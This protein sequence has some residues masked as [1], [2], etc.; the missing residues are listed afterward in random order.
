MNVHLKGQAFFALIIFGIFISFIAPIKAVHFSKGKTIDIEKE[1]G[2]Y[3]EVSLMGDPKSIYVLSAYDD[4]SRKKRIQ[5]SQSNNVGELLLY[6]SCDQFGETIYLEIECSDNENCSGDYDVDFVD[7]IELVDGMP[8]NYYINKNSE[9]LKFTITFQLDIANVW[10]RGQKEIVTEA[11]GYSKKSK[12]GNSGEIYIFKKKGEKVTFYVTGKKGDYINVGFAEYNKKQKFMSGLQ[13]DGPILTGYL[14]KHTLEEICY[15]IENSE[16]NYHIKGTGIIFTKFAKSYINVNDEIQIPN[17]ISSGYF[18]TSATTT[19]ILKDSEI[20]IKF[21]D[22]SNPEYNEIDEI[23]YT[24]Q[25]EKIEKKNYITQEPQLN[26]ILYSR[27]LIQGSTVAYISHKDADFE[28]MT[29]SLNSLEGFPK[30][31]VV[32]CENYPLCSEEIDKR[33]TKDAIRPRNIN[34]FSSYNV[35][36]K[37][38]GDYDESPI[39]KKQTLF[40]VECK[41]AINEYDEQYEY[42]D[43]ICQYNSLIYKDNSVVEL[44]ERK[45]YNQYALQGEEH[46]FKILLNKQLYIQ[47]VFIDVMTYVGEVEINTDKIEELEIKADHYEAIHKKYISVKVNGEHID[48]L[49]FKVKALNNTYYTILVDYALI[50][51]D[52]E[53]LITNKLESGMSYLVTVDNSVTSST[54]KIIQFVNERAFDE[55][56][57]MVNFYSLNCEISINAVNKDKTEEPIEQF[58]NFFNEIIDKSDKKYSKNYTY[59]IMVKT[60]DPSLFSPNLCKIYTSAIE[61]SNGHD[62][63]TRDILIPDNTPQQIRF[64]EKAK[65]FSIGY[66]HVNFKNNLMIKFNLKQTARYKVQLFYENKIRKQEELTIVAN[67]LI[68]LDSTE[69]WRKEACFDESRVCYIQIDIV[70]EETKKYSNP[71][72]ELSVKSMDSHFVDYIPKNQLKIDYVQNNIPQYYYTELGKNENGFIICN[73]LRGS[74]KVYAKLVPKNLIEPETGANW[75]GKYRLPEDEKEISMIPFT[76]KSIFQ[77]DDECENGCY[78]IMTVVSDVIADKVSIERNYPYSIIIRSYPNNLNYDNI[79]KVRIPLDQYI[80]GSV[81]ASPET[82]NIIELYTVWLDSDADYVIIDFQ[83]DAGDMFINVGDKNP[84]VDNANFQYFSIGKDTIHKIS[85]SDILGDSGKISLRDTVLTIGIWA[86]VTDSIFTTTFSFAIRLEK[87]EDREI[88]RVSSDQKVL[89]T[90]SAI[91]D[92]FEKYRCVYIMDYDFIMDFKGLYVY[93]NVQDKSASCVIYYDYINSTEYEMD[94]I[95]NIEKYIPSSKR[96]SKSSLDNQNTGFLYIEEGTNNKESYVIVSV[97]VDTLTVIELMTTINLFQEEMTVNPTSPQ[98]FSLQKKSKITLK[99][100]DSYM[101]MI[102]IECV[103]GSGTIYWDYEKERKYYLKGRDDRL[104]ITSKK[105]TENKEHKL[106]IENIDSNLLYNIGIIFVVDYNIRGDNSNFDY[107]NLDKSVN[108]IY[109][110]SDFPIILY[111]P[112]GNFD[113]KGQDY[114]DIMFNFYDLESED[115]K[116]LTFYDKSPFTIRGYIVKESMIYNSKLNPDF[117]PLANEETIEGNYDAAIRSG[118]IRINNTNIEKSKIPSYERPYLYLKLDKT[119]EFRTI[120]KYKTVSF[121]TGV[122]HKSSNV[123]ISENSNHFG[124][125][126]KDQNEILYML[127]NDENKL[128]LHLEFSCEEDNLKVSIEG[129]D[130]DLQTETENLYGKKYYYLEKNSENKDLL[131]LKIQRKDN[132]I[133]D[134][135]YF[136]FKY[137]YSTSK[138]IKKYKLSDTKL[139]V[140]QHYDNENK[141]STYIIQMTPLDDYEKYNLTYIVKL[142]QLKKN[143]KVPSKSSIIISQIPGEQNIKE[144]YNPI[145]VNKNLT[146]GI[147]D[148]LYKASYIQVTVQIKNEEKIE[149]ISYDL[150]N[151]FEEINAPKDDDDDDDD[152]NDGP[153]IAAII[154]GSILLVI[155]VVLIIVIY[156]FNNKNRDLLEKVNKVSF[157]DDQRTG[158][159]EDL[160]LSKE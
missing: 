26:G 137:S 63:F 9:K 10:A 159:Y 146:L 13:L 154:I 77:T 151:K 97:E 75:R 17:P 40:V 89:C 78:L 2:K 139:K 119:D 60:P 23:I 138:T 84:S 125:L 149:F 4:S 72:L 3:L 80:V 124:F 121:E 33:E 66:I 123:P 158:D 96:K 31:Y 79:P 57:Y 65:H 59:K 37:D 156:I 6:L 49:Y 81:S 147:Y 111:A 56:P 71:V 118:L 85:K 109:P 30:M 95:D 108:Y 145:S 131:T 122:F 143:Q 105:S 46:E 140:K 35:E 29:L 34:R 39:S 136:Y 14:E 141:T 73:F 150:Q 104:S 128:Y 22:D 130:N 113:L 87:N 44:K 101:E 36:K 82:K 20:C 70:L 94:S 32:K 8:I 83:S 160:L 135:Q 114:Y 24:L 69:E 11:D 112:F 52:E 50:S 133:K 47:K 98:L 61:M 117:S 76:K 41:R 127:R 21:P 134:K 86:N 16:I 19:E 1:E 54:K 62:D 25:M 15:P 152:D 7:S 88:Y 153:L 48:E 58:D 55:I 68:Y 92:K 106:V 129:E 43:F 120:R 74:G 126:D 110:D 5:F 64:G 107:L 99:F 67:N 115:E 155:V 93:A 132:T 91:D 142:I 144:F 18:D 90:P 45:F 38:D 100:P 116:I 148:S 28:R 157:A 53:A 27:T 12:I 51:S 103:G 42:V 102:N